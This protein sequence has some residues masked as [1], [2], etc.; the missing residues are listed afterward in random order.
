MIVDDRG[1]LQVDV[2][3]L[4][5]DNKDLP[6]ETERIKIIVSKKINPKVVSYIKS[7]FDKLK[8]EMITIMHGFVLNIKTKNMSL[9]H[10]LI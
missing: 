9:I 8:I 2:L 10:A 5:M 1:C 4:L 7:R 3:D 6:N